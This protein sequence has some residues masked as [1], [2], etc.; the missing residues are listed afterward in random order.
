MK[1]EGATKSLKTREMVKINVKMM[2]LK[3]MAACGDH[4]RRKVLEDKQYRGRKDVDLGRSVKE[5]GVNG[6][7]LMR[8][9]NLKKRW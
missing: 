7:L 2:G 5:G 4:K 1:I 8:G 6:K 3:K 9:R